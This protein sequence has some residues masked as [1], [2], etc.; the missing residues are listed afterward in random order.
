MQHLLRDAEAAPGE[1]ASFA[2]RVRSEGV[3]LALRPF[4]TSGWSSG[5]PVIA[6]VGTVDDAA[7]QQLQARVSA[8]AAER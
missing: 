3:A 8:S 4:R 6:R 2:F 5:E 7:V 1:E